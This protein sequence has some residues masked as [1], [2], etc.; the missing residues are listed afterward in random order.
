MT[1]ASEWQ[2]TS[3]DDSVPL[4]CVKTSAAGSTSVIRHVRWGENEVDLGAHKDSLLL[5]KP[6]SW[7]AVLGRYL[8]HGL[9]GALAPC[10]AQVVLSTPGDR[11]VHDFAQLI[12][13]DAILTM[14]RFHA[15]VFEQTGVAV[16]VVTMPSLEVEPIRLKENQFDPSASGSLLNGG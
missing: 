7:F 3:K 5:S 8:C 13:P 12:E 11:S 16:V 15:D 14:E 10:F 6:A 1:F 4:T 2:I 9:G